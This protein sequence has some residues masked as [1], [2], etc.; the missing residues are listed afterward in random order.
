MRE[1]C[2]MRRV[3][4]LS[5]FQQ[6]HRKPQCNTP[7]I[8]QS[9]CPVAL[10]GEIQQDN[11]RWRWDSTPGKNQTTTPTKPRDTPPE[12]ARK[13]CNAFPEIG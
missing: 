8:E 13:C 10:L 6:H 3:C 11:E 4:P 2:L 9:Q 5:A 7:V 1:K 12:M